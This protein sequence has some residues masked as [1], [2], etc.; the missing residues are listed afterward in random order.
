M[1]LRSGKV[2][3]GNHST[4]GNHFTQK[5]PL[6]FY[7]Q[8][9]IWTIQLTSLLKES[10]NCSGIERISVIQQIYTIIYDN[11]ETIKSDP[12]YKK[13]MTTILQKSSEHI[14]SLNI[15]FSEMIKNTSYNKLN[16]TRE[17]SLDTYANCMDE[18]MRVRN[19]FE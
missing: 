12:M 8:G 9:Q 2:I 6:S 16:K 11:K 3:G 14:A 13:L 18:I 15:L 5:N 10:Q 1:Q 4:K 7:R 19:Y 17:T